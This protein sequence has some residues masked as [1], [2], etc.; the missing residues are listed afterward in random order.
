MSLCGVYKVLGA[1][2]IVNS[3]DDVMIIF[4]FIF[5]FVCVVSFFDFSSCGRTIELGVGLNIF[6]IMFTRSL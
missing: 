4:I 2:E 5:R 3:V 6:H 1:V